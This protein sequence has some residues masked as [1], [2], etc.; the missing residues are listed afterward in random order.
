MNDRGRIIDL[1]YSLAWLPL[2][3]QASNLLRIVRS[4]WLKSVA[5]VIDAAGALFVT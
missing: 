3:F 4:T 1:E 5:V 2:P